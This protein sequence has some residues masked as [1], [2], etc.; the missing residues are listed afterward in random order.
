MQWFVEN[1][2]YPY[3]SKKKKLELAEKT[4]LSVEQIASWMSKERKKIED[5]E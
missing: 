3:P 2:E 4:G 5:F 1:I